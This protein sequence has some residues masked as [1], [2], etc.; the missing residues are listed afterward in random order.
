MVDLSNT[1]APTVLPAM[2]LARPK[3]VGRWTLADVHDHLEYA[4]NLEIWTIPYYLAVQY[5]IKDTG[6]PAFRLIRSVAHQEMLHA[7]LAANL[8]GVDGPVLVGEAGTA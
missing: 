2:P 7:Q 5:S 3:P 6:H 1:S 4:V 8:L